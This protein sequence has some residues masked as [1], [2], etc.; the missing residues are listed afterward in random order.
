L[1]VSSPPRAAS[2]STAIHS[3]RLTP[4]NEYLEQQTAA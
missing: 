3:S 2:S 1:P 4:A